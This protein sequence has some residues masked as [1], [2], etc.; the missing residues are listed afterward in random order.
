MKAVDLVTAL[1]LLPKGTPLPNLCAD[2]ATL[3]SWVPAKLALKADEIVQWQLEDTTLVGI[4][5]VKQ[6]SPNK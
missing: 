6:L 2:I 1:A 4:E 5:F 3:G